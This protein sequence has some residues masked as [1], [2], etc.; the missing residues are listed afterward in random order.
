MMTQKTHVVT[1]KTQNATID[2]N[3]YKWVTQKTPNT[4][5][6]TPNTKIY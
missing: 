5:E 1:Q 3:G 6:K 2:S 4:N